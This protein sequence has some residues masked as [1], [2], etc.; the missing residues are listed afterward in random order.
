M[1]KKLYFG[2]T[3]LTMEEPLFCEALLTE[4][5]RILAVGTEEEVRRQAAGAEEI[6]LDG[7]TLMPAF[8]D[9][10]S[11]FSA[12]AN[13]FLQGSVEQARS[14]DE[15]AEAIRTYI[16]ENRIPAGKWVSVRDFDPEVL[17]E[18]RVPD[19]TVLDQASSEHP[20]VLQHKS[21]HVGV[22]NSLALKMAGIGGDTPDPEGGRI[23]KQ[24]GEPTGYLEENAFIPVL[25]RLP[26]PSGEELIAAYERAQD[27]YAS[28]GIATIQ[29]GFMS[30]EMIPVY[31]EL[32]RTHGLK[33]DVVGYPGADTGER[34]YQA[35]PEAAKGYRDRFRLGGFKMF[36]DGSP[37]SRTAWM[38]TPYKDSED[39]GYPVLTDEQVYRSTAMAVKSGRQILAHCN[40]DRAA[41]QY[42]DALARLER[43]GEDPAAVRPVMIHAQ[44]LGIDQIPE[45]KRL[46]V[47]PSFFVAHVYH[48]GDAHIRNF[49]AERASAISPAAS[50]GRAGLSYTFHQDAP[51]IRPDMLE[52]VWC[53]VNRRTR[54]GTVLGPEE[55]VT[56][57][58]ALRAVTIR[59]AGQY[60]EEKEKGSLAP[61]KR[62][63]LVILD[64]NP[65]KTEPESLRDLQVLETIKDGKTIYRRKEQMV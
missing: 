51:V 24:D 47:I 37:Q 53:A 19:K 11:H 41:K 26:P 64:R 12:C 43:E 46:G 65:L 63:D 61:G 30:E 13:A 31:R 6:C 7:H 2:G 10:H 23:W 1:E 52:T 14:F 60:F 15:I 28:Y 57:E 22:L 48:W 35:F 25:H 50:A 4:D 16:R 58:E 39:F 40:G 62:A 45:L 38:R 59:A 36:L 3:V 27:M 34:I 56:E 29:E 33:L 54:G 18:G 8:I 17:R 20:I 9:A 32:C 42:L 21:G 5:G 55:G 49:G 44:L